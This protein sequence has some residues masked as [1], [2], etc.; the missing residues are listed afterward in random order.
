MRIWIFQTGEPLHIDNLSYRPMRAMNL[1]NFL[2]QR[3]HEVT[4]WSSAF[5][6]QEKQHRSLAYQAIKVHDSLE[7]KLIPS[8]GYKKNIGL[9]RIV[10]HIRLAIN[11]RKLLANEHLT[12]PDAAFVGYPPIETA[13]V[14]TC[15]LKKKSIPYI[16]DV[17]DQWPSIFVERCP[18]PLRVLARTFFF[19]H[20]LMGKAVLRNANVVSS[21]SSSFLNWC[22]EFSGRPVS[23]DGLVVPLT[24]KNDTYPRRMRK[25]R[26]NAL[27]SKGV[28]LN[29]GQPKFCF[30]GSLSAAFDFG[31]IF[32]AAE[33]FESKEIEVQFLICGDGDEA[34]KLKKRAAHLRNVVFLGWVEI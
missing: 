14:M 30:V 8:S 33:Q 21:I 9:A 32:E 6:H 19:L 31:P 2:V 4:I 17:K 29:D 13:Y 23:K 11:L 24:V 20:F 5:F 10:D 34:N 15:W 12:A 27:M 3:G 1:A 7:I 28:N 25:N 18:K 26:K 22:Y 16:V